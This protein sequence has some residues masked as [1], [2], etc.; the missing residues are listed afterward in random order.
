MKPVGLEMNRR[1]Q[2]W[3][4]VLEG[5]VTSVIKVTLAIFHKINILRYWRQ[6]KKKKIRIQRVY[7]F[8]RFHNILERH[9]LMSLIED[10][11]EWAELENRYANNDRFVSELLYR[12]QSLKIRNPTPLVLIFE[13][14]KKTA[15]QWLGTPEFESI[16]PMVLSLW[17][18]V[19]ALGGLHGLVMIL[20][21]FESKN[22]SERLQTLYSYKGLRAGGFKEVFNALE[23]FMH[24]SGDTVKLDFF[25]SRIVFGRA[26]RDFQRMVSVGGQA[27]PGALTGTWLRFI[28]ALPK[29]DD[30]EQLICGMTL[31]KQHRS[32]TREHGIFLSSCLERT[33]CS[34]KDLETVVNLLIGRKSMTIKGAEFEEAVSTLLWLYLSGGSIPVLS[35]V[36]RILASKNHPVAK[37]LYVGLLNS[38]PVGNVETHIRV[39]DLFWSVACSETFKPCHNHRD[40]MCHIIHQLCKEDDENVLNDFALMVINSPEPD[41]KKLY[42][43]GMALVEKTESFEVLSGVLSL[44]KEINLKLAYFTDASLGKSEREERLEMLAMIG[45]TK[46]LTTLLASRGIDIAR[47]LD[48]IRQGFDACKRP[49]VKARFVKNLKRSLLWGVEFEDWLDAALQNRESEEAFILGSAPTKTVEV[50]LDDVLFF[51][52]QY[53]FALL[54]NIP[55][56]R[57]PNGTPF[58]NG[59]EVYLPPCENRYPDGKRDYYHNRNASMF[60]ANLFHEI[61]FHILA[62][63]F[64]VDAQPT[65]NRFP[66]RDMAHMIYNVAEDFRGRHH[67]LTFGNY[68]KNWTD[69]VRQD[70]M[71]ITRSMPVPDNW[72]DH[73]VQLLVSKATTGYTPGELDRQKKNGEK[74][75]L[76]RKCLLMIPPDGTRVEKTLREVLSLL[77]K[78]IG[79]LAGLTVA[80]TLLLVQPIYAILNQVLGEG[81]QYH[82]PSIPPLDIGYSDGCD[83]FELTGESIEKSRDEQLRELGDLILPHQQDRNVPQKVE[84]YIMENHPKDS[85]RMKPRVTEASC[86]TTCDGPTQKIWF[87][88]YDNIRGE[89]VKNPFPVIPSSVSGYHPQFNELRTRHRNVFRAMEDEIRKLLVRKDTIEFEGKEPDDILIENL[90]EAIA[91]PSQAPFLDL[92]ENE[93]MIIDDLFPGIEVKILVD[94][95]AST[96]GYVLEV[97]KVFA[98]VLHNAFRKLDCRVDIYFFEGDKET[99][100]IHLKHPKAIGKIKSGLANRD[101]AAIRYVTDLFQKDLDHSLFFLISDGLPVAHEYEGEKAMADTCY[102]MQRAMEKGIMLHY[103]NIGG[104]PDKIYQAF[105]SHCKHTAIFNNPNDL[106]SY[107]PSFIRDLT[108]EILE[109][110]TQED[111]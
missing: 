24:I 99:H 1:C 28:E 41:Q 97:E 84:T 47:H 77:V 22:A 109:Y 100:V 51:L 26:Y 105:K 63:S 8:G 70:E 85:F 25:F 50:Q 79:G 93:E 110:E 9:P 12:M 7:D 92:F 72:K 39:A 45:I 54:G 82:R 66:N 29:Y 103:F 15:L 21:R 13:R 81:F 87:G 4:N 68:N 69:I 107:A 35:S 27:S 71:L 106:I 101:G 31:L 19:F 36:A 49:A 64:L 104:L 3:I 108:K 98:L 37:A 83:V 78:R 62:G 61:G 11:E 67:F 2:N 14:S 74:K 20:D 75:L 59:F 5:A 16:S 10:R 94:C 33:G 76:D 60:V 96:S 17:L 95:S 43:L 73:F 65:I 53:C 55:I 111:W 91:D 86:D 46:Y 32:I 42:Q 48:R 44:V 18:N 80:H 23:T 52:K 102:A 34:L 90:I 89:E 58:T 30:P 57:S 38:R 88:Q 6:W 56:K 40:T